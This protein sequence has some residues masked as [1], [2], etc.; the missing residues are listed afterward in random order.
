MHRNALC[1]VTEAEWDGERAP[2]FTRVGG[3]GDDDS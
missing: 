3:E 2:R 1:S